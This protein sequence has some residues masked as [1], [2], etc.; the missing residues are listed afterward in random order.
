VKLDAF[1]VATGR[2]TDGAAI[3]INEQRFAPNIKNV[4]SA[5]ALGDVMDGN[6]GE[7]LKFMPGITAEYDRESG[8]SV[9]LAAANEMLHGVSCS[10][11]GEISGVS[12]VSVVS[13]LSDSPGA[14]R[15]P[16]VWGRIVG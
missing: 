7:F 5:D 15:L 13:G 6:V 2:E 1:V 10:W 8:G 14:C 9:D 11:W 3:A 12:G 4:V 16:G